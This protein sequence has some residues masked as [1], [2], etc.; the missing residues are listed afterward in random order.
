MGTIGVLNVEADAGRRGL[1]GRSSVHW[2]VW[3]TVWVAGWWFSKAWNV[4]CSGKL[5]TEAEKWPVSGVERDN[6]RPF[7]VMQ[8]DDAYR[9]E[10]RMRMT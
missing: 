8:T 3:E 7:R 4:P 6:Q 2:P 9:P 5:D 1:G 10:K